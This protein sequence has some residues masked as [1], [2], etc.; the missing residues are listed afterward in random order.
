MIGGKFYDEVIRRD[1]ACNVYPKRPKPV[2]MNAMHCSGQR[3]EYL[4]GNDSRRPKNCL[5][6]FANGKDLGFELCMYNRQSLRL[7]IG[8]SGNGVVKKLFHH[9]VN[10]I[11]LRITQLRI[12]QIISPQINTEFHRVKNIQLRI[13]QLRIVQII[14]PQINTE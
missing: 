13:T 8:A 3:G 5:R 10:N 2:P 6:V 11:Q 1:V 14:S 12:V 9:R 4:I 7:L